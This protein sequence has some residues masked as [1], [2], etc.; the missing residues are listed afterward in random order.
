MQELRGLK[1]GASGSLAIVCTRPAPELQWHPDA[2]RGELHGVQCKIFAGR[3]IRR[4][5]NL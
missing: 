3:Y 1:G 4:G 5:I 2:R